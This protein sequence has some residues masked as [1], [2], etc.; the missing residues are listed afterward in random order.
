MCMTSASVVEN[1]F[2]NLKFHIYIIH[3]LNCWHSMIIIH[4]I[5]R[6]VQIKFQNI[7][8]TFSESWRTGQCGTAPQT[9]EH[10]VVCPQMEQ[11]CII[12]EDLA[13]FN[14]SA[15]HCV[16]FWLGRILTLRLDTLRR[17]ETRERPATFEGLSNFRR[18]TKIKHL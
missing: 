5:N 8:S 16:S 12:H 4:N 13:E 10:V 2:I 9:M 14:D 15:R 6:S 1:H 3:L 17:S 18:R 11:H 7:N